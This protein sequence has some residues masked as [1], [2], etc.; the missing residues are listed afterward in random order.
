[1]LATTQHKNSC[2]SESACSENC[3]SM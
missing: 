2:S 3:L 1:L